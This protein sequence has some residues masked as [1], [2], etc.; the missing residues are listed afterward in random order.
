MA[1][2]DARYRAVHNLYDTYH[3]VCVNR[4]YYSYRLETLKQWNTVIEVLIAIGVS[5]SSVSAAVL[6]AGDIGNAA[7]GILGGVVSILA[8]VKPFLQLPKQIERYSRLFVGN[9]AATFELKK[10]VDEVQERR[11][12]T[13][14]I[15]VKYA[16]ALERLRDVEVD[17]DPIQN[18][19]LITRFEAEVNADV[20]EKKLW[21][22]RKTGE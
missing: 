2:V 5:S 4:K 12:L 17:E 7:W 13:P 6:L 1:K 3:K 9:N 20:P 19:R 10:L 21:S 18:K 15:E 11:A 22:P 8:I 16:A 14:E